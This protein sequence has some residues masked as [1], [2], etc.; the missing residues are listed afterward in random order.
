MEIDTQDD[1]SENSDDVFQRLMDLGEASKLKKEYQRFTAEMNQASFTP[2]IT[3]TAKQLKRTGRIEEQ[4]LKK[5]NEYKAKIEELRKEKEMNEAKQLRSPRINKVSRQLQREKSGFERLFSIQKTNNAKREQIINTILSNEMKEVT[6]H[7][8]IN[9]VSKNLRRDVNSMLQWEKERNERREKLRKSLEEEYKKN[10]R[11]PRI[12]PKSKQL[13]KNLRK[14]KIED[15]LMWEAVRRREA[16]EEKI[17]QEIEKQKFLSS[18][19]ISRHSAQLQRNERIFDRLYKDHIH[20]E[21][22][23]LLKKKQEEEASRLDPTGKQKHTPFINPRS[24]AIK[25]D[26]PVEDILYRKGEEVRLKHQQMREQEIRQIEEA[27]KN[28]ISKKSE[29]I[30]REMEKRTKLTT[31]ERITQPI[32]QIRAPTQM[33]IEAKQ[34]EITHKPTIN[35]KSRKI[36]KALNN[37][38]VD[39]TEILFLKANQYAKKRKELEMQLAKEELKQ[40]SF[41][42]RPIAKSPPTVKNDGMDIVTR[43]IE[44]AKRLDEKLQLERQRVHSRDEENCT[45]QPNI[46]RL[47]SPMRKMQRRSFTP[48]TERHKSRSYSDL[49]RLSRSLTPPANLEKQKSTGSITRIENGFSNR[50]ISKYQPPKGSRTT[51]DSQTKKKRKMEEIKMNAATKTLKQFV[52]KHFNESP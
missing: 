11:D 8:T 29:Q 16:R 31:K 24:S 30:V 13:A 23:R 42:P 41:Q 22:K 44:W 28:K 48:P 43:T 9:S 3:K 40:C 4:L 17:R 18:P 52:S 46:K 14:G 2:R 39:R 6:G 49:L 19:L 20:I 15:I 38:V 27:R 21:Q 32:G 37:G 33:L 12:N 34:R 47:G 10:F 35:E 51:T 7:P 1:V 26:E 5:S 25:R 50:S 36:D 45:F